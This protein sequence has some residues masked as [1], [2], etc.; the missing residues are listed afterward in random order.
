MENC[1]LVELFGGLGNQLFQYAAAR[2]LSDYWKVPL[3]LTQESQN[4][5][6]NSKM[7]YRKELRLLGT[8]LDFSTNGFPVVPNMQMFYQDDGFGVWKAEGWHPPMVLRGYFQY[9]P[10]LKEMLP[11]ICEELRAALTFRSAAMKK[12]YGLQADS[13]FIHVRRGDYLKH[14]D[15]HYVQGV[16][17]YARAFRDLIGKRGSYPQQIYIVSD[18]IPWCREQDIFKNMP[19]R[20][21]VDKDELD[22]L[23]IMSLCEG[24]AILGNSTFSWWGAML[25]AQKVN[26]PVYYPRRWIAQP[27]QALFPE[28]W[29]EVA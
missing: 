10:V 2:V 1:V 24:G 9:Y 5:H 4:K 18:D 28:I 15:F 22:T 7:D 25:G 13:V 6:N 12:E 27:I 3:F 20:V 29:I 21:Y 26:A 19:N 14:S 11:T 17:Y 8:H 23:A 16:D